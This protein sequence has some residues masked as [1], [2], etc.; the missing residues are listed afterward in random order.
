M[1]G[2]EDRGAPLRW[3]AVLL[4]PALFAI[5]VVTP[6]P[7]AFAPLA[8][9]ALGLAAWMACWWA[10]E[11]VPLTATALLPLVVV[12]LLG[13][14]NPREILA[15][16]ANS[17]IFLIL[18]GFLIAIAMERC[19]LHRR[20]AYNIVARV[21]DD[22]ARLVLG[23]MIATA[24]LS[25][26]V[27][28]TSTALMMLP[29]A[30][31]IAALVTSG[32]SADD[33][34]SVVNFRTAIT[35][36][37]AYAATIGGLGTLIGTPTNALVQ[38]FAARNL[39]VD[40]RF[41]DWLWF[42]LPTVFLML[43]LAWW[44]L[45]R[46]ALPFRLTSVRATS[47]LIQDALHGLGPMSSAERKVALVAGLAALSWIAR[48]LLNELA[49][50]ADL[51]DTVIAMVA[52]LSLFLIPAA[53]GTRVALLDASSFARIPWDVLLL[54]GG[55]LALAATI[56]ASTLSDTIGASLAVFGTWPLFALVALVV[57]TLIFWTEMNSNVAT[58]ATFL[59]VLAALAATTDYPALALLAPAAMAAS[60]AFMMPV[61]TPANAIVFATGQVSLRQMIYA[62]ALINVMAIVVITIVGYYTVPFISPGNSP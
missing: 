26:W 25:M 48:P 6:A 33:A 32:A 23:V 53:R 45:V 17:T 9:P 3:W 19:N 40:L 16:Y 13:F 29:V 42:G 36:C 15:E 41:V 39:G 52:G 38:A 31:S 46:I 57:T 55:G 37:V 50:L 56:Q 2:G 62:G 51:N 60:A 30:T 20:I 35:L 28:N 22:P 49:W 7:E 58:A 47:D 1:S 59:P 18:G 27:S 5:T 34:R 4:G 54:F 10:L 43:P 11:A 61:G 14:E 12:P 44:I 8:W 24:L 21:G